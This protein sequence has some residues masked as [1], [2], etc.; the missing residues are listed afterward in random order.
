L[1]QVILI[2][3]FKFSFARRS[4]NRCEKQKNERALPYPDVAMWICISRVSD[5]RD[6]KLDRGPGCRQFIPEIVSR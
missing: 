5:G 6:G 1:F 2:K 3:D 4:V